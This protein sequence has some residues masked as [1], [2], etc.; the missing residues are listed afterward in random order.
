[1]RPAATGGR[2]SLNAFLLRLGAGAALLFA[3]SVLYFSEGDTAAQTPTS[4]IRL[5]SGG[6][7]RTLYLITRSFSGS[8]R[9]WDAG[10]G[11]SLDWA[12][13]WRHTHVT[14][15]LDDES[16]A[17]HAWGAELLERYAHRPFAV[18]YAPAPPAAVTDARP[19]ARCRSHPLSVAAGGGKGNSSGYTRQ[20]YDT[21]FLDTYLP[22][23][24]SDLDVVGIMDVDSPLFSLLTP[25]AVLLDGDAII[26]RVAHYPPGAAH[27]FYKGDAPLLGGAVEVVDTMFT[28]TGPQFFFV[29]TFAATR[30]AI[31]AAYP[32]ARDVADA[33][34]RAVRLHPDSGISPNNVLLSVGLATSPGRYRVVFGGAQFQPVPVFALNHAPAWLA[35][36]G[37][38]RTF[39]RAVLP[40]CSADQA[41]D[42]MHLTYLPPQMG[43]E[44]L[45]GTAAR[46]TVADA[47]YARIH[48]HLAGIEGAEAAR[49]AAACGAVHPSL[50]ALEGGGAVGEGDGVQRIR[51]MKPREGAGKG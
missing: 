46:T 37:C 13:D 44:G 29:G 35:V 43:E 5:L 36:N 28:D 50:L 40:G 30:A 17:D 49:M 42:G 19:F 8:K 10:L 38:C 7:R 16:P 20:L 47:A 15:V 32:G 33:W 14:V 24:S 9:E 26:P 48:A 25:S 18:R 11:H 27:Q 4:S 34:V 12:V 3:A 51:R 1:M 39:G 31:V 23:A 45:W 41:A 6:G 21:F 2:L 22:P